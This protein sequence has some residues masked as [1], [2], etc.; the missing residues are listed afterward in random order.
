ML[1]LSIIIPVLNEETCLINNQEKLK[2]LLADG[3]EIL[4]IDGGSQDKSVKIANAIGC[5][6]LIT[7]A[8]RGYQL[9]F[10]AKH[11]KNEL[12]LFLHAD[13]LLPSNAAELILQAL[14][15][16]NNHWGRF[17][18]KFSNPNLVFSVVA[19]FM[20]KRSY[21]TAIVTGDQAMF[22]KR[23]SYFICGG[24]PDFPIMEDIEISKR[25][26]MMALPICLSDEV[27]SSS[28]KWETQGVLKTIIKMWCL[29]L[30][31]FLGVSTEKLAKS[32]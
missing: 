24:F 28:R 25:L 32:Y 13:T 23:D 6:T 20:N 18:I 19:W 30:M 21:L 2:S 1:K 7:K 12:L 4:V 5:K 31:F 11:S 10:G 26:K 3:H 9:H 16:T 29:R 17:N 27:I 15:P 14:T 22:I 8:S